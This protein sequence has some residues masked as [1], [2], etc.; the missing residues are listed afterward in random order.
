MRAIMVK[1]RVAA[2][3]PRALIFAAHFSEA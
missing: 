1:R 2:R 3:T